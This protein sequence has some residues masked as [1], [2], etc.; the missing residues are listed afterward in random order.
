MTRR[1][2]V[3]ACRDCGRSLRV[4]ATG[5]LPV[6]CHNCRQRKSRRK[7]RAETVGPCRVCADPIPVGRSKYCSAGC[8]RWANQLLRDNPSRWSAVFWLPCD[9]CGSWFASPSALRRLCSAASCRRARARVHERRRQRAPR[10]AT[11]TTYTLDEVGD[12]D[13][14]RCYLCGHSVDRTRRG[15][16]RLTPTADHLIPL[17]EG[18]EDTFENVALAHYGCNSG[19]GKRPVEH[20]RLSLVS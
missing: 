2:D 10:P 20:P 3:V 19:R 15:R 6:R 7:R 16:H 17:S 5:P 14:W 11:Y 13:G 18:G 4:S 12:R 1:P 9:E 8:S